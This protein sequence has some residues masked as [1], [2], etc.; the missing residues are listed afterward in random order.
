MCG[1]HAAEFPNL[2]KQNK[3][4]KLIFP[5]ALSKFFLPPLCQM[6]AKWPQLYSAALDDSFFLDLDRTNLYSR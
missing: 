6:I 5:N 3:K 4:L 2:L 1:Q